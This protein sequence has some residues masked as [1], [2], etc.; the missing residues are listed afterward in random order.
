MIELLLTKRDNWPPSL[1][2]PPK[3]I[4]SVLRHNVRVLDFLLSVF[5]ENAV[6]LFL[7]VNE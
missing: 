7:S 4:R 6:A 1:V 2:A 3:Q 5:K